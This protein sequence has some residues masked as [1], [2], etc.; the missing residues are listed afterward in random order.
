MF[1]LFISIV[2]SLLATLLASFFLWNFVSDSRKIDKK[3]GESPPGYAWLICRIL[4]Q[5]SL[6]SQGSVWRHWEGVATTHRDR[7][8]LEDLQKSLQVTWKSF[9]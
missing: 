9:E 4:W 2:T 1:L 6:K 5:S 8:I 3:L 7:G